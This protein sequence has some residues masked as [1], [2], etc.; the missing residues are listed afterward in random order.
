MTDAIQ[1]AIQAARLADSKKAEEIQVLDLSG[2]CTFT[3]AFVICSGATR[4]QL[5]AIGETI[6][7]GIKDLDESTP[8]QDGI[9]SATWAVLDYG[10]FVVHI[11]SPEARNYYRLEDIW[12][13]AKT[14]EWLKTQAAVS[15]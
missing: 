14:V 15:E 9:R 1:R 6:I 4:L 5:K 7:K 13:D 10:D 2:I 8:L 12:G 11:M 3:D